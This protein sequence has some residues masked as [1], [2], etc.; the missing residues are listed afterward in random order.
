MRQL[1]EVSEKDATG[2]VAEIYQDIRTRLGLPFVNLIYRH[3]ATKPETLEKIWYTVSHSLDV[4]N[5]SGSI[6][7]YMQTMHANWIEPLPSVF[8]EACHVDEDERQ[9]ALYT[10]ETYQRANQINA[11]IITHLLNGRNTKR[12]HTSTLSNSNLLLEIQRAGKILPMQDV[13]LLS[14]SKIEM[15]EKLSRVATGSNSEGNIIP[16]LIRHFAHN[17]SLMTVFWCA[18]SS[19]EACKQMEIWQQHLR[20][21]AVKDALLI[22]APSVELDTETIKVLSAFGNQIILRM[23]GVGRVLQKVMSG[24]SG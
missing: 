2:I 5:V 8:L 6:A 7:E 22:K 19:K 23:L 21:C 24:E 20:E 12:S 1:D 3:L 16:S 13:N 17:D 4:G 9:S 11:V 10:L 15:L 18:L 14:P